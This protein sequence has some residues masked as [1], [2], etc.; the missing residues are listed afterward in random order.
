MPF[1]NGGRASIDDSSR[2]GPL[3]LGRFSVQEANQRLAT[4]TLRKRIQP[5][6]SLLQMICVTEAAERCQIEREI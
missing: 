3:D 5:C 4:L 6:S 2:H 1:T